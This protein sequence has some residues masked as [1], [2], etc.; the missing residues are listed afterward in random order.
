MNFTEYRKSI[1][2]LQDLASKYTRLSQADLDNLK[3]LNDKCLAM[4]QDAVHSFSKMVNNIENALSNLIDRFEQ[5]K[6]ELAVSAGPEGTLEDLLKMEQAWLQTNE[7]DCT[8]KKLTESTAQEHKTETTSAVNKEEANPQKPPQAVQDLIAV[9]RKEAAAA[10]EK[11][12]VSLKASPAGGKPAAISQVKVKQN[13]KQNNKKASIS[14]KE[15][16]SVSGVF[17]P[18]PL[19]V[20]KVCGEAEQKLMEEINKNIELIKN[21]K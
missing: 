5:L 18:K 3:M 10:V 6:K 14:K 9:A 13:V 17:P 8:I 21:K 2:E 20:A 12:A 1:K 16:K 15:Q 4:K 19:P 7:L 11:A